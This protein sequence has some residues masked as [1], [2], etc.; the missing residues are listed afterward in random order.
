MRWVCA[1]GGTGLEDARCID[2]EETQEFG[3]DGDVA[4]GREAVC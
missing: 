2:L 3:G 4:K 1:G